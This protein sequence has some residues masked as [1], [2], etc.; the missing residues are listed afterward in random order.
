MTEPPIDPMLED[1]LRALPTPP[2]PAADRAAIRAALR[3]A[4]G[5]ADPPPVQP[6]AIRR[7]SPSGPPSLSRSLPAWPLLVAVAGLALIGVVWRIERIPRAVVDAPPVPPIAVAATPIVRTTDVAARIALAYAPRDPSSD[8]TS[9][10]T[11]TPPL[12]TRDAWPAAAARPPA[13]GRP[14]IDVEPSTD[15]GSSTDVEPSTEGLSPENDPPSSRVQPTRD[16]P[17]RPTATPGPVLPHMPIAGAGE[18]PT[19][20]VDAAAASPRPAPPPITGIAGT[21]RLDGAPFA[22]AAVRAVPAEGS[23]GAFVVGSSGGDGAF[24]LRLAPGAWRVVAEAEGRWA[25]WWPGA[26]RVE[27]AAVVVVVAGAV[28][29]GIDFELR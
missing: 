15:V 5:A 2:L 27:E 29:G 16:V 8:S 14:S 25:R 9:D 1:A 7:T 19:P 11:S 22:F 10:S 23:D 20:T 21:V 12:P 28:T 3:A 24:V 6:T 4:G 26:A 17:S 18:A 13:A